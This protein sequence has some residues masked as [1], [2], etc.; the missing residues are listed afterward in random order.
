MLT[1]HNVA[2]DDTKHEQNYDAA[3][4]KRAKKYIIQH[5]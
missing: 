5:G 1:Q 3:N 2:L 4:M